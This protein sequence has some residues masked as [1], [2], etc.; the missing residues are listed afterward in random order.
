MYQDN[1]RECADGR[2]FNAPLGNDSVWLR[3]CR[4]PQ[5]HPVSCI[6]DSS[7]QYVMRNGLEFI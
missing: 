6:K 2:M 5:V 4:W 7:V 3:R 1:S